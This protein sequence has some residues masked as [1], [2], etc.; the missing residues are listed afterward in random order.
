MPMPMPMPVARARSLATGAL[1][2]LTS[3]ARKA[4]AAPVAAPAP[5]TT[6]APAAD[7]KADAGEVVWA[8]VPFEEDASRGKD[9]PVLVLGREGDDLLCLGLSSQDHDL[10]A[11]QEARAGRFWMD[12][13][14]GGWDAERR[15]SEVRLDRLLR[16]H[17]TAVRRVGCAVEESTFDAV[18]A[19]AR[20][21]GTMA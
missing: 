16:L 15:P 7:D 13:G 20:R 8:W 14:T 18:V 2:R 6:Y 10:D 3:R 12:I 17:P 19:E 1:G 21:H 9:R 5:R 4:R 11:D